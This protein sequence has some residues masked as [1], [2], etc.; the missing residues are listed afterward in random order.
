M[1]NGLR[2]HAEEMG[3]IFEKMGFT[4]MQGR[5]LAYLAAV[6]GGTQSFEEILQ[7]FNTSKST[8][9]NSLNYLLSAGLIDYKTRIG[10]RKRYFFLTSRFP[11]AYIRLQ[12]DLINA[13]KEQAYKSLTTQ[14]VQNPQ[15]NQ[16]IHQWI[17]FANRY[18]KYLGELKQQIQQQ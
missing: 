17:D 3:R 2:E 4:P 10:E 14:S 18:E 9:S 16:L 12:L 15:S 13:F 1:N 5:I 7:F 8:V 11:V 6:A